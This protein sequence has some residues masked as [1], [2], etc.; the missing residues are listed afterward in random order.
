MR[1]SL[2]AAETHYAAHDP[3]DGPR[4]T[5]RLS[6]MATACRAVSPLRCVGPL[7]AQRERIGRYAT[8]PD[9][10]AV[11]P[12]RGK[13]YQI[14]LLVHNGARRH[15]VVIIGRCFES[16]WGYQMSRLNMGV[17]RMS[18]VFGPHLDRLHCTRGQLTCVSELLSNDL[19]SPA[20]AQSMQKECRTR[21]HASR[22]AC[23]TQPATITAPTSA[24]ASAA[25]PASQLAAH[26]PLGR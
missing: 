9:D 16:R 21:Q 25:I 15:L 4:R 3:A 1:L 14:S 8:A 22:L 10:S 13:P 12:V 26:R 5:K 19:C 24:G 2:A 20:A 7:W 18:R 11:L 17:F 6:P 23:P